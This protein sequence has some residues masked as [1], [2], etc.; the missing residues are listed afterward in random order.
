MIYLQSEDIGQIG[1]VKFRWDVH[2]PPGYQ[3]C[4]VTLAG[5]TV[6]DEAGTTR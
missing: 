2:E 1:E 6:S 4:I 3:L 5:L